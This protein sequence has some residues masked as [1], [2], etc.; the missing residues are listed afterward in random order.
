MA[1]PI[2]EAEGVR[3][4]YGKVVALDGFDLTAAAGEVLAVLGPNGAGK[5]T[6]V[7]TVAT[8]VRPDAGSRLIRACSRETSTEASIFTSAR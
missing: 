2:V 6:F 8:L 4:H 5:T 3:R 7:R 1:R